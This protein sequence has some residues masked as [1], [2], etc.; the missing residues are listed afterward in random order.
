M[1]PGPLLALERRASTADDPESEWTLAETLYALAL[2][3]SMFFGVYAFFAWY[4]SP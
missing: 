1:R 4:Y 3:G 2:F